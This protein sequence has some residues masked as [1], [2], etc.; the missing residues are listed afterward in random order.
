[1][2]IIISNT[3]GQPIYEQITIQ[4]KDAILKGE[5]KQG[6]SLP[7]IRALAKSLK[8]SVITAQ[9]AYEALQRDGF[10]QTIQG[11]G[12]F[13][14]AQS[15]ELIREEQ[16]RKME[17]HLEKAVQLAHMNNVSLKKLQNL[18]TL[19]YQDD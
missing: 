1:M 9:H 14:A 7:S 12:T 15:S 5:L 11:K 3:S 8:I 2:D 10:I 4:I 6:D 16:L 18:I 17:N 13:I 19:F